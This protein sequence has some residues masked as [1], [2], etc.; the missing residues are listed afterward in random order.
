MRFEELSREIQL[1]I[2]SY[3]SIRDLIRLSQVSHYWRSRVSNDGFLWRSIYRRKF[4]HDFVNDHWILWAV[5]RLWSQS[6]LE[7][8]QLA[9]R[10]VNLIT[11][12]HLDGYTWY[13]LVCGRI[14]TERNWRNNI[15]QRLI[16]FVHE[17]DNI[18]Q[19]NFLLERTGT[20]YD[21]AFYPSDHEVPTLII[22]DYIANN[23]DAVDIL[24]S[25]EMINNT[26]HICRLNNV[27]R[28]KISMHQWINK[29]Y[30]KCS[31]ISEEYIIA[32]MR[33]DNL[34]L[35]SR[36]QTHVI[37]AWDV[38]HPKI[39]C[40]NG[41][42]YSTPS[43]CMTELLPNDNY[44]TQT[45]R[46]GWLLVAKKSPC[47]EE[48]T[49]QKSRYYMLYDIRHGR[50]AASFFVRGDMQPIL[51]KVLPDMVQIYY[52]YTIPVTDTELTIVDYQ[53]RWHVLE[54]S[55]KPDIP[56]ST[57]DFAL[58]KQK[59]S[60]KDMEIVDE[61]YRI[62]EEYAKQRDYWHD[63]YYLLRAMAAKECIPLPTGMGSDVRARHLI[64]DLFLVS[65][66]EQDFTYHDILLAHS[67]YQQGV[68]WWREGLAF[69]I[70]IPEE[71]TILTHDICG[72][73]QLLDMY[74]GKILNSM[75]P[76]SLVTR[77]IIGPFCC[78]T[79]CHEWTL[80]DV[81][82]GE[83]IRTLFPDQAAQDVMNS[84]GMS[85]KI[86][87]LNLATPIYVEYTH[88]ESNMTWIVEYAQV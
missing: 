68:A 9:A 19:R 65:H 10:H 45:Q 36:R 5:R 22:A 25:D 43:L 18:W 61:K 77:H 23:A 42:H 73:A 60:R 88:E 52:G 80:I 84:K 87:I 6:P 46:G 85:S 37:L 40:I 29:I 3:L 59:P 27:F 78:F 24:P 7:E 28:G 33:V 53:Y 47:L 81:R 58:P 20:T 71:K 44:L 17:P 56:S 11:L 72:A 16:V 75:T 14:L 31:S 51:G 15:P 26:R 8:K 4:G 63:E 30:F 38:G 86:Q 76:R 64:D 35:D 41:Q 2:L 82:T 13:R 67:I 34:N 69:N 21:V 49:E 48:H 55:V 70:L 79:S 74:T 50:L 39:Q 62:A 54:V 12:N 57:G 32:S 66:K 83:K 1:Y